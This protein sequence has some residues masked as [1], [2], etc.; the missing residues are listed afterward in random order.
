MVNTNTMQI[1]DGLDLATDKVNLSDQRGIPH[2]FIKMISA[3]SDDL[4]VSWFRSIATTP[5]QRRK[6]CMFVGFGKWSKSLI[7]GFLVE[8]FD[9][10][11][12]IASRAIARYRANLR[13]KSC[14]LWLH[15]D[16]MV[17]VF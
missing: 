5:L 11:L 9:T 17:F 10:S 16:V 7:H 14:F 2:P 3:I 6:V 13:L 15:A 4:S 12:V 1:Y 8:Q